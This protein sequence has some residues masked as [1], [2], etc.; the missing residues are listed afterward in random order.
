MPERC[1]VEEYLRRMLPTVAHL[2]MQ[3]IA[4]KDALAFVQA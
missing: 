1:G 4:L 2:D 3:T